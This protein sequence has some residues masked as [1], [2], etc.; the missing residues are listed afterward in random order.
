MKNLEADLMTARIPEEVSY[1]YDVFSDEESGVLVFG[2]VCDKPV[3]EDVGRELAKIVGY[4][5]EAVKRLVLEVTDSE[6]F[7][8]IKMTAIKI[9]RFGSERFATIVQ[10]GATDK[11]VSLLRGNKR[12]SLLKQNQGWERFLP[13]KHESHISVPDQTVGLEIK[14]GDQLL[15]ANGKIALGFN[16]LRLGQEAVGF[17]FRFDLTGGKVVGL[18]NTGDPINP[19]DPIDIFIGEKIDETKKRLYKAHLQLGEMKQLRPDLKGAS[20]VIVDTSERDHRRGYKGLRS[21]EE[22][23]IGRKPSVGSIDIQNR[24]RFSTF[25]SLEQLTVRRAD[26]YIYIKDGGKEPSTNGTMVEYTP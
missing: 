22:V 2:K 10:K 26:G 21:T 13:W 3:Y 16:S 11:N 5:P 12:K 15:L 8:D 20:M 14:T 1:K 19:I 7:S 25:V 18:E 6:S 4:H 9:T 24:F 17:A 23:I